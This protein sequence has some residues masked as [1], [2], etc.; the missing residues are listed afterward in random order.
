MPGSEQT[1]GTAELK[2]SSAKGVAKEVSMA[3]I[4]PFLR[5]RESIFDPKDVTAMSMALD[6]VCNAL[7]LGPVHK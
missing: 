1:E 2:I 5:E 7:S 3:T 6:D 4:I